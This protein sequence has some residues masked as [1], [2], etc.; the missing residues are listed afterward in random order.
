[1][2]VGLSCLFKRND[3]HLLSGVA[4]LFFGEP[5]RRAALYNQGYRHRPAD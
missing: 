2:A 1:M 5:V 4:E 3:I